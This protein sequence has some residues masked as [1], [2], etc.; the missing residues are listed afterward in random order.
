MLSESEWDVTQTYHM[1][2]HNIFQIW[3]LYMY[4]HVFNAYMKY[5]NWF[6]VEDL[7]FF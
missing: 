1:A 6:I 5:M 7:I 4:V 3:V 2:S